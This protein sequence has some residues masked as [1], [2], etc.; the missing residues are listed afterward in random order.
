M[1]WHHQIL[2]LEGTSAVAYSVVLK[3]HRSLELPGESKTKWTFPAPV[4][5]SE[6]LIEGLGNLYNLKCSQR[7]L[8]LS[9]LVWSIHSVNKEGFC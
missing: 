1:Q 6:A 8:L 7:I 2:M 3:P 4:A 9:Q 5:E